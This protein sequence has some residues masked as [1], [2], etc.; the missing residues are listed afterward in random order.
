MT[1]LHDRA[2]KS[3][4]R[5]GGLVIA[6]Y[7]SA[8]VQPASVDVRLGP[9]L[10]VP[11]DDYEWGRQIIDPTA[12]LPDDLFFDVPIPPEGFVLHPGEFVLG[13]VAEWLTLPPDLACRVEGRSSLG[14]LG[15][16]VHATAG[17]ADP[18]Y[19]GRLTLEIK[20]DGPFTLRLRANMG[21][22]QLAFYQCS[23]KASRPYGSGGLGS[24]YQGAIG[25]EASK[26]VG[27]L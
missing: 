5:H 4:L 14:R 27:V 16:C 21:I 12:P 10:L 18:G 19:K 26:G 20:N 6:P 8:A 15:L 17:W 7:D 24:R 9:T 23:G 11:D 13:H 3:A 1:L 25:A 22:G 2:I